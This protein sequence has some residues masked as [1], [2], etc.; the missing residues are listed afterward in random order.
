MALAG[1]KCK[2]IAPELLD[3]DNSLNTTTVLAAYPGSGKR[4]TWRLLEAITGS[5]TGDDWDLSQ[6]GYNNVLTIKTSYPHHEGTWKWRGAMDQVILLV[7]NPRYAVPSYYTMRY[8]LDFSD[9]WDKSYSRKEHTYTGRPLLHN[10]YTWRNNNWFKELNRWSWY[11]DF[12]MSGGMI[13]NVTGIPEYDWHCEG[14]RHLNCVPR[15]VIHFEKLYSEDEQTGVSEAL[16]LASALDGSPNVTVIAPEAR[17]CIY[18]EVMARPE[19][20]NKNRDGKGSDPD[21]MTFHYTHLD[22][23][24]R[25][26]EEYKDKYSTGEWLQN[27]NAK[28]L[29]QILDSYIE[30]ISV[31]YEYLAGDYYSRKGYV[32]PRIPTSWSARP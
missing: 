12:W 3:N 22:Y 27:E 23:Y 26:L 5:R 10:W 32:K 30:E 9:N 17:P 16:R 13:R 6:N 14:E 21:L 29:V 2:W 19:F 1:G 20:Y 18:K 15:T 28:I 11:I 25:R 24:W 31:E 7:R 4:L 8:E